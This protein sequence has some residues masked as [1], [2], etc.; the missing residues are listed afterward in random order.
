MT[1]CKLLIAKML[2][3]EMKIKRNYYNPGLVGCYFFFSFV[4]WLM[5]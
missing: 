2:R 3:G 5:F 4:D 1:L